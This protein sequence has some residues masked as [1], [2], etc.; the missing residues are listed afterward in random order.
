MREE[1]EQLLAEVGKAI[2]GKET[3]KKI[4]LAAMFSGGHILL[5]DIPGV[6]K[7]SLA[8]SLSRA[9]GLTARRMQF[10]SDVLPADV[11]GYHIFSKDGEMQYMEGVLACNLFLADE[12]NRTSAK[13]Q[14]AL[15]EVMEEGRV[16]V[17]GITRPVPEPFLVIATEN[18]LGSVGTQMLPESQLDR[19]MICL[20]LGYPRHREEIQILKDR[21][22]ENPL[23][24]VQAVLSEERMRQIRGEVE[25]VYIAD[26]IY[27]YM[28]NLAEA[29]RK[30]S[31][32]EAG[33]SPRG[34]LALARIVQA[35]AW[36]EDRDFVL[37][38]DAVFAF[39]Y[40]AK[41]RI[42]FNTNARINQRG[43]GELFEDILN[44]VHLRKYS[45]SMSRRS[46]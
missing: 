30:H 32:L 13:T 8:L 41:H 10:T 44:K 45:E 36:M 15:L 40:I 29:T 16:T 6:G 12:I 31:W 5:E 18:P 21:K 22:N 35:V 7:T 42:I 26:E 9:M 1:V 39:P 20:S 38:E 43:L 25:N 34:T 2:I 3:E 23:M 46:L 28:V 11:V 27:D 4:I 33:L 37:P 17:D 14:S 19:F 24:Q